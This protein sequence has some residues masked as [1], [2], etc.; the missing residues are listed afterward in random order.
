[1][2]AVLIASVV[3]IRR[4]HLFGYVPLVIVLLVILIRLGYRYEWTG[5]KETSQ[6]KSEKRE[7][8]PRKTLWGWMQLLLVPAMLAILAGGLT[9]WQTSSDRAR[10]A[11]EAAQQEALRAQNVALQAYIDQMT[12]LVLEKE[13]RRPQAKDIVIIAQARTSAVLQGV[14]AENQRTIVQFLSDATLIQGH[15]N[16]HPIISLDRA[17]LT[18]SDLRYIDL[19]GADLSYT[20]LGDAKLSYANLDEA[21]LVFANLSGTTLFRANLSSADLRFANLGGADLSDAILS[22]AYLSRANLSEARGW[23]EEQLRSAESLEGATM[24][25]GQ[26]YEDWLKS[27]DRAGD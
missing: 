9:W 15:G 17:D 22:G 8:Q 19:S 7:I 20:N 16:D 11:E 13:L 24:P 10:Q 18:A 26:K 5:F 14:E 12:A 21:N 25:N 23:T 1:M 3:A 2:V 27:K 4:G 6:P